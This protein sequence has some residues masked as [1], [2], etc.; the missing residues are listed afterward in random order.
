M[1]IRCK[2]GPRKR[3]ECVC[4]FLKGRVEVCNLRTG[5]D[6]EKIPSPTVFF[7]DGSLA[8]VACKKWERTPALVIIVS[9][10]QFYEWP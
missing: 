1:Y 2:R 4:F 3:A 5:I 9:R 10:L 8:L 7:I 6:I